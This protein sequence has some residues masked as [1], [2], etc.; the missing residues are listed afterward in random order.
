MSVFTWD[1]G[2]KGQPL[3]DGVHYLRVDGL[4]IGDAYVF[5]HTPGRWRGCFNEAASGLLD[6]AGAKAW[7]KRQ[8]AGRLLTIAESNAAELQT[9]AG[10]S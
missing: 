10:W 4:T 7:V 8:V 9:A 3:R 5:Q 2:R 1:Y 6:E